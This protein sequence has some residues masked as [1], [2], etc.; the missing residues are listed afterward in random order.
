MKRLLIA[1]PVLMFI[2][3][4]ACKKSNG[5]ADTT[6]VAPDNNRDSLVSM[7]ASINGVDWKTDSAYGYTVA[8]SGNDSGKRNL[9]I[10]ATRKNGTTS[11]IVFNITNYTG[12]GD[13]PVDP[14]VYTATYYVGTTRHYATSG[15]ISVISDEY[16]SLIGKFY[17][18]A[19]SF[20]VVNGDFN[21]ARP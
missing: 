13:Y 21:V 5:P 4:G 18:T 15:M 1:I 12:P 8:L 3:F 9:M 11:T 7:T 19:D 20:N 10:S 17:F 14:P 6:A 2:S 16:Y